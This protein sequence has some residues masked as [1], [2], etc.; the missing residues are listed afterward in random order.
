MLKIS[1]A[2]CPC[3]TRLIWTQFA[4]EM[5]LAARNRQN[6]HKTPILGLKVNVIEYGNNREPVYDFLLVINS[7]LSPISHR[8][9]DTATYW[10][11]IANFPT[12][13]H[14]ALLFGVTTSNS[15]KSFTIPETR[16]FQAADDEDLMI[17]VWTVFDWSTRVTD[18]QTD[19]HSGVFRIWQRGAM[20][21]ARS[22]SL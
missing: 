4:L 15:W 17:V 14:L 9:W 11:K 2:A 19:G 7:N 10:L 8:Y 22:A 6:I 1:R 13:S 5:C 16:V 18:G 3:L 20:A 12:P 21:S